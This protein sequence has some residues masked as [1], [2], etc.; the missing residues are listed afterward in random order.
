MTKLSTAQL[1]ELRQF[2]SPTV[3]NAIQ[4]FGLRPKAE[5]FMRSE[6]RAVLKPERPFVGYAVTAKIRASTL[7]TDEQKELS[8]AYY[9]HVR[10]A[11]GPTIAVIED[12]DADPVGSFWGEVQVTTHLA[13]GCIGTITSGGVRDL[14]EVAALGFG[15]LARCVLV[16]HANVHI[17]A[18]AC[19]VTVGGLVVRPGDLLFADQ[20]GALLIPRRGRRRAGRRVPRGPARRG[21]DARAAARAD[22][23]GR[24][25]HDGRAARLAVRDGQAAR[26]PVAGF[27]PAAAAARTGAREC[28]C[29]SCPILSIPRARPSF[30]LT[31]GRTGTAW[32]RSAAT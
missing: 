27:A 9:E 8:F 5:G 4:R 10:S 11:E 15:Y 31:C 22:Q 12:L 6:I 14:D 23:V 32:S 3:S 21:A 18:A 16:S 17:E 1:E 25:A 7:P 26:Q 30:P 20:H 24:A 2:D 28:G 29:T 19:P 13:L